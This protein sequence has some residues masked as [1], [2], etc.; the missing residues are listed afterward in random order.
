MNKNNKSIRKLSIS[1]MTLRQLQSVAGGLDN[2]GGGYSNPNET[3]TS[4]FLS[5]CGGCVTITNPLS[6][7]GCGP[8]C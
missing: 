6:N 3:C 2:G 5:N 8:N 1:R 7:R 4:E